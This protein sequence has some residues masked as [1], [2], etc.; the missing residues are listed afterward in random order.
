MHTKT[1]VQ[2][3]ASHYGSVCKTHVKLDIPRIV[4]IEDR[5][6]C[7]APNKH[8]SNGHSLSLPPF[9]HQFDTSVSVRF[10]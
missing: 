3:D 5:T 8:S 10:A 9:L 1:D 4:M 2:V 6:Q 7:D